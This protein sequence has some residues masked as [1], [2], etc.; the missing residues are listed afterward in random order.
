[1]VEHLQKAVRWLFPIIGILC[2]LGSKHIT[3]VLPYLLGA[4]MILAGLV[5]CVLYAQSKA[6]LDRDA[7]DLS[8]GLVLLI[9]GL[10]FVA[11]GSNALGAL[12]TTW[13]V[14]GIRKASKSLECAIQQ[15]RLKRGF[16]APIAE[17]LVRLGL[18]LVLLFDPSEKFSTHIL[19]LGIE[20][21]AI[22]IRMPGP[23]P[24]HPRGAGQHGQRGGLAG[25]V[26][27]AEVCHP[28]GPP[29]ECRGGH[30]RMSEEE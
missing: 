14:I 21:I 10:V 19:I 29:G 16:F 23:F 24:G 1:M 12:G 22:S 28:G 2:I 26:P 11:Q 15:I 25:D 13:A 4:A 17:F 6:V 7:A 8:Y 5:R 30:C 18:A 3:A 9:M 27:G 20:L